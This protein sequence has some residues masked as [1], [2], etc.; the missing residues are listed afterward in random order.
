MEGLC[1]PSSADSHDLLCAPRAPAGLPPHTAVPT[2]V[3]SLNMEFSVIPGPRIAKESKCKMAGESEVEPSQ[4]PHPRTACLAPS[5]TPACI[6][7]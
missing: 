1:S 6:A 5:Q 4:E 7:A 2:S 3:H